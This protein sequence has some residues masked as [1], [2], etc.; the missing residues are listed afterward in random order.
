MSEP[1]WREVA[2]AY[3]TAVQQYVQEVG[4][5]PDGPVTP[6]AWEKFQEWAKEADRG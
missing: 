4:P 3:P 6:E 2:L 5:L 1:T